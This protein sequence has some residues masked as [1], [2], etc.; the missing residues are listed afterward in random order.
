[1]PPPY[2]G[3]GIISVP[4]S[5][6]ITSAKVDQFPYFFTLKFRKELWMKLEL[7]LTPSLKSVATLPCKK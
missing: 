5:F 7:K 3:G 4:L 6:L 1:M 2:G